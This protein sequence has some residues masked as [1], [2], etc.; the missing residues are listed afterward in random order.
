MSVL[1]VDVENSVTKRED[2]ELD[3]KPYRSTNFLVSVG[4]KVLGEGIQYDFYRHNELVE[5]APVSY[6]QAALD[7]ATL[8]VGHNLRHDLSWL[9]EC[10][11]TYEGNVYDTMIAEYVMLRGQKGELSLADLAVK[12]GLPL[13]KSDLIDDYWKQ[14]IGF[15]AMPME[16]VEEYGRADVA[17]TE[18]LYLHQ[19]ER[20]A[21]REN[22]GL[23]PVID[24][25]NDMLLTLI[26]MERN[27][28]KIDL[29]ALDQVEQEFVAEREQLQRRLRDL[30]HKLMGDRPISLSSP[31]QLSMVL[32]SRKV[33]DK[34]KWRDTFNLG[35]D[36][37]GKAK[38]RPRMKEDKFRSIINQQTEKLY[39]Q[40]ACQCIRCEGTGKIQKYK[41]NGEPH[42]N[43]NRCSNC[44][45]TGLIYEDL[46]VFAGLKLKPE[47]IQYVTANGFSTSKEVLERYA[48]RMDTSGNDSGAQFM[49]DL[50]RLNAV[51]AYLSSFVGGIRKAVLPNG[52]LHPNFNQCVTAT[53]RLSSSEPNFQNQ[54]RGGTFPIRK[55][56]VSRFKGGK[57]VEGDFGSLEF[58][59]GGFLSQ[60]QQILYDLVHGVDVHSNTAKALTEAGQPTSR[61]D[62]KSRTFRPMYGGLMG[63]TAEVAYFNYFL[64][65]YSGL[66]EWH[67]RLCN[68]A[69]RTGIIKLPSGR[70]YYFP[71]AQRMYNGSVSGRTQIVN[72][73]VQGFATADIVP[74]A[75]IRLDRFMKQ[76]KVSAV[77]INTVHD[78]IVVDCPPEEEE[79]IIGLMNSA[80]LSVGHEMQTRWN[81]TYNFPLKVEIKSGPNWMEGEVVS[82]DMLVPEER[83][84]A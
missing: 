31:E 45:A 40:K 78:S 5:P 36:D 48:E 38:R 3:N 69:V 59:V 82:V 1:V 24:L 75:C 55:C 23:L 50:V 63:T 28:I 72:Y 49:R 22:R 57:I 74:L 20:L 30:T 58:G 33:I 35:T 77:L 13:K 18:A 11:F 21:R 70:E 41:K 61:Q 83:R 64:N 66:A 17:T 25:M 71:N 16:V 54:P 9:Y 7:R 6:L 43:K 15:E 73:P 42:K 79:F 44:D 46:P 53:G 68:E 84:A 65:R 34:K 37:N 67:E 8:V 26:G 2:G 81:C 19:Q 60:D 51:D 80:M 52:F 56:I 14:G 12:H 29:Q 39:K 4:Y 27:G 47:S 62:A 32:Y 10:G 76:Y